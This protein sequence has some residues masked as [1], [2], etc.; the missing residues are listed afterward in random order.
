MHR[1]YP[2]EV[3]NAQVRLLLVTS[4]LLHS[5]ACVWNVP[6]GWIATGG[7][8]NRKEVVGEE[9]GLANRTQLLKVLLRK[10]REF[11]SSLD[12]EKPVKGC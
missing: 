6:G 9:A 4:D 7:E 10:S 2:D 1:K 8:A 5:G 3:E 12:N 11:S